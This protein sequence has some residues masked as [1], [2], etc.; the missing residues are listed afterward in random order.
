MGSFIPTQ[1][2]KDDMYSN[3]KKTFNIP[4][5][6]LPDGLWSSHMAFPADRDRLCLKLATGALCK[7]VITR[8]HIKHTH[9]VKDI[10][11]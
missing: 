4:T 6:M 7:N 2:W 10:F 3:F 1:T 5:S 8:Y 9:V 11:N